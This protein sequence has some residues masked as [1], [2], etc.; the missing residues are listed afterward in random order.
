MRRFCV[1]LAA[2]LVILAA[3][4][5]LVLPGLMENRLGSSIRSALQA[6]NVTVN[7]SALP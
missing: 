6:E 1:V 3:F 5:Q 2:V 7:M 4:S